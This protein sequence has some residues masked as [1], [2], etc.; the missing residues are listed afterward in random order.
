MQR[1][2]LSSI[3]VTGKRLHSP[4]WHHSFCIM[5]R[6]DRPESIA[7][8]LP[9]LVIESEMCAVYLLQGTINTETRDPRLNGLRCWRTISGSS[10]SVSLLIA[11]ICESYWIVEL[12]KLLRQAISKQY[13]QFFFF[14]LSSRPSMQSRTPDTVSMHFPFSLSVHFCITYCRLPWR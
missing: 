10:P 14:Y 4:R 9:A 11:P 6:F 2:N 5:P 12:G 13:K 7:I 8:L 3:W 1:S